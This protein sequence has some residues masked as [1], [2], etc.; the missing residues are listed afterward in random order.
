MTNVHYLTDW[1]TDKINSNLRTLFSLFSVVISDLCSSLNVYV[2]ITGRPS[3]RGRTT[4]GGLSEL[5]DDDND[6]NEKQTMSI[7]RVHAPN[8]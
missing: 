5:T 6:E 8:K 3:F 4:P 1:L 2:I 7:L